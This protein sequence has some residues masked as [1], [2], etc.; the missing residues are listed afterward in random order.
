MLNLAVATAAGVSVPLVVSGQSWHRDTKCLCGNLKE[1]PAPALCSRDLCVVGK[2]KPQKSP[3]RELLGADVPP[4]STRC[5]DQRAGWVP[6]PAALLAGCPRADTGCGVH[7][8]G[9]IRNSRP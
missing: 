2:E 9:P 7:H 5:D 4:L 8:G 1:A 6:A 3:L